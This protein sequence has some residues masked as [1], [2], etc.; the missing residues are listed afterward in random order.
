MYELC[1]L[2]LAI[3]F[4]ITVINNIFFK[5]YYYVLNLFNNDRAALMFYICRSRFLFVPD[6]KKLHLLSDRLVSLV[7]MGAH[8]RA[9]PLNPS[10]R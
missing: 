3:F 1:L 10:I 8:L 2:I 9:P 5:D 4:P 7:V 6:W